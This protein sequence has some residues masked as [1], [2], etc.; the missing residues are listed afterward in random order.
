MSFVSPVINTYLPMAKLSFLTSILDRSQDAVSV[1]PTL[2]LGLRRQDMMIYVAISICYFFN[3]LILLIHNLSLFPIY[4]KPKCIKKKRKEE[5]HS[6]N[7]RLLRFDGKTS[8]SLSIGFYIPIKC[9]FKTS[10]ACIWL[11]L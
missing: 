11:D 7:S 2:L 5:E 8:E 3:L 9:F 6:G 4:L 10:F 1:V